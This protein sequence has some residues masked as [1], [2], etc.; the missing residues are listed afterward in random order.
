M[1]TSKRRNVLLA[2]AAA[3]ALSWGAVI[4][5]EQPN[6]PAPAAGRQ[7]GP[8]PGAGL[9]GSG[10]PAPP[11]PEVEKPLIPVAPPQAKPS[12]QGTNVPDRTRMLLGEVE[13]L[14]IP[15][16]E[17]PNYRTAMR[18]IVEE[19]AIYARGRDP[20]F[21]VTT[22]GGFDLLAWSRREFDLTE[23]KRDPDAKI[24]ADAI[25]QI[26]M[27]L[28]LYIQQLNGIVLNGQFCAPLR[29][30]R[31]NLHDMAKQGLKLLS[32]EHCKTPA[33][34]QSALQA[35]IQAGV[36]AHT[37]SDTTDVFTNV[38]KNRPS[39]EN[40]RNVEVLGVAKNMLVMLDNTQYASHGEWLAALQSTNY[41]V[42]VTDAFFK[43]KQ[44]LTKDEIHSLKFK[45]MG[46][47]RLVLARMSV[48]YAED[49]RYYWK[50]EW[51]IGE[52]SWIKPSAR[53]VPANTRS[54]IGTPHGKPSSESILPD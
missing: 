38:P 51:G 10:D 7:L 28:R 49:E 50:R 23:I 25:M 16:A 40:P 5:A 54:S 52:P 13:V 31:D 14:D 43:G 27:P 42:L 9:E 48:G 26:G 17:I 44:N 24:P 33:T 32:I 15:L 36:V 53:I 12:T 18:S 47:R 3:A 46:A 11:P 8:P 19:L 41:D 2:A 21:I 30:P 22:R 29:V 4:A 45:E 39:P 34:A 6:T 20:K 1:I 35:A 37:D